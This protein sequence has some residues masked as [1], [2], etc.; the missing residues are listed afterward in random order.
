MNEYIVR[1]YI[2]DEADPDPD[3]LEGYTEVTVVTKD[4]SAASDIAARFF[5]GA[6]RYQLLIKDEK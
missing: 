2:G 6:D 5:P 4:S 3:K 1:L